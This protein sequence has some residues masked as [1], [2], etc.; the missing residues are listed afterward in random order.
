[1][2]T[3]SGGHEDRLN[4]APACRKNPSLASG[5]QGRLDW[6]DDLYAVLG[7]VPHG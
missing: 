4:I 1:M 3:W 6:V 7:V 5:S 2:R